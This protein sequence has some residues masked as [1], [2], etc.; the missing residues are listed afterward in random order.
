MF[1]E[2]DLINI[3]LS[4]LMYIFFVKVE[5][6]FW[7]FC[8]IRN[9]KGTG[10]KGFS[11]ISYFLLILGSKRFEFFWGIFLDCVGRVNLDV[12]VRFNRNIALFFSIV[13]DFWVYKIVCWRIC[14]DFFFCFLVL[15]F[16][17]YLFVFVDVME[18]FNI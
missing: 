2:F 7:F 17:K 1:M 6:V 3:F 11:F 8:S 12:L 13:C 10:G 4:V 9:W 15:F 16:I 18:G 5:F 14:E